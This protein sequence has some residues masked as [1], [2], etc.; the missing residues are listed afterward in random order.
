MPMPDLPGLAEARDALAGGQAAVLPNPTPLAY[1]VAA[2]TPQVVNAAKGRPQD[3]EVAA[4][5]HDDA[6]WRDLAP[7]V[8]L[9]ADGLR[10]AFALLRREL[11]TLLV[12]LRDHPPPP[13]WITPALRDGH[14]LLFGA[15]WAPL[16]RLL[17]DFPKLYVSSAN[18]TGHPPAAT[19]A[20]AR[21]IF[22]VHVPVVDAD[23]LHD[24]DRPHS[25]T[26]MLRIA[27][28]GN[29]ALVRHGAQDTA[30][31]RDPDAYLKRLRTAAFP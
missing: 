7:A 1:G 31:G 19:A 26:T 15:R 23:A 14:A 9:R 8:D 2:T 28:D 25:S 20:Q 22:G 3:Q 30:N 11:V 16:T 17:A 12:P 6:A 24:A 10:T 13:A 21:I 27:P 5:L 4:W 29:L 18:R